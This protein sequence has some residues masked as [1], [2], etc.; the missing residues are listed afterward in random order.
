MAVL[1]VSLYKLARQRGR[2]ARTGWLLP[3]QG[4]LVVSLFV[5][6][7][8]AVVLR[9][10]VLRDVYLMPLQPALAVLGAPMLLLIAPAWRARAWG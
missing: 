3:Y 8:I 6:A 2:G 5:L 7:T 1:G 4:H 9:S 10:A